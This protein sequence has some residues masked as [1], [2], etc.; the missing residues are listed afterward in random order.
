MLDARRMDVF[1]GRAL[2][3]TT[4]HHPRRHVGA[5]SESRRRESSSGLI[6]A[7]SADVDHVEA[8][9]LDSTSEQLS[10]R[11]PRRRSIVDDVEQQVYVSYFGRMRLTKPLISGIG[12]KCNNQQYKDRL[13]I[14]LLAV[15]TWWMYKSIQY[16]IINFTINFNYN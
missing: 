9:S 11:R 1:R 4:D 6:D 13:I 14:H 8:T 12:M 2:T 5:T 16:T 15:G 10:T 7:S 3:S